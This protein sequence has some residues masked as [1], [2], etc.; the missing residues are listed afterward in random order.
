MGTPELFDEM[1]QLNKKDIQVIIADDNMSATLFLSKPAKEEDPY[2]YEE[3]MRALSNAG[4]KMGL[5]DARI[6]HMVEEQIYNTAVVVAQGKMVQD[7]ADGYYEFEFETDLKAKPSVR[8]DGSVDYYNM[9]PKSNLRGKG[10]TVS[11]DG[12]TYYAAIDGKVE[13]CNYDLRI[14]N[15]LDISGDVDLNIGNIDFN[16][17]VNI[18][19]NVIT[20]VTIRAMGSIYIGGYVEGA[21]I[22]S[23]KDIVLNKGVNANGIGQIEAKG[24]I[25]AHFFENAIVYAEGDVN[26]GYILSSKI[27]ALGKVIVQGGGNA[28][29]APTNLRIGATKKLRMDYANIIVQLKDIDSQIEMY[30]SALKK[31][32]MVRD[33][34]P[35]AFDSVSYTKICQSKIIKSAEKAKCE[36]ESKR[37]YDLIKESGKA[38]VK[39]DSK[40]FPGARIYIEAKVYEPADTLVHVLVRKVNDSIVV[41]DYEE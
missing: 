36:Q 18:T 23:N 32:T 12:N 27:M 13:Y 16:G 15:V 11:E 40:I 2:T 1:G 7:G 19:G 10:F 21:V 41:R 26:A 29:Y 34:K 25:S 28:S 3:V 30:E 20:G 9:K 8:E 14:V 22:K 38:V 37:L 39:V 5:D 33:V 17:D 35:E 31:L 6:H 4:V 24:N